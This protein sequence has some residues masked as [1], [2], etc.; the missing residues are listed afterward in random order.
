[1]CHDSEVYFRR[2]MRGLAQI[3]VS[4]GIDKNFAQGASY[5]FK[6]GQESQNPD[7]WKEKLTPNLL[8]GTGE[9]ARPL[10]PAMCLRSTLPDTL[11]ARE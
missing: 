5:G 9:G 11:P 10:D 6:R 2:G 7:G 3:R 4:R 8:V 1:M